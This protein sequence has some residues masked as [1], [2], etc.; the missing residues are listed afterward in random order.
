MELDSAC[1]LGVLIAMQKAAGP[2]L[3]GWADRLVAVG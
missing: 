3:G 2:V 1:L